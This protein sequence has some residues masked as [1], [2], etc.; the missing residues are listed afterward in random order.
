MNS[1][2]SSSPGQAPRIFDESV[3]GEEDPGAAV[4]PPAAT[5]PGDE[6]PAGTPGTGEK[7]C[8]HC[9][10]TGGTASGEPCT[11]CQGTGKVTAGLGGG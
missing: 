9:G 2:A 7:Q 8:S 11:K 5:R 4:E 1:P 3:A 10:G 6:A